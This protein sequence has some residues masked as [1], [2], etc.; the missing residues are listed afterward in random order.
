MGQLLI[1][2]ATRLHI[3]EEAWNCHAYPGCPSQHRPVFAQVLGNAVEWYKSLA[4][5]HCNPIP[6]MG[7]INHPLE[8]IL[9]DERNK[10]NG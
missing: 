10:N 7:R 5:V 8:D 9:Y 2:A 6:W 4:F 1:Q 3:D